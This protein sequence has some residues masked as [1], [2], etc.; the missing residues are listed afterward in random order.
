MELPQPDAPEVPHALHKS[1][2]ESQLRRFGRMLLQ[3]NNFG[4]ISVKSTKLNLLPAPGSVQ[5]PVFQAKDV[6]RYPGTAV[7]HAHFR[8]FPVHIMHDVSSEVGPHELVE[9]L[10]SENPEGHL[11]VT[12]MNPIEVL[13]RASSFEP[14]SH[15]IEYDLDSF[16]F[17]F[18]GSESESYFT[19][20]GVT[21]SWLRTSSV[22]ASNGRIY[23]VTLLDYKLGHCVWHIYCG[24]AEDQQT[25]TFSTGSYVRIPAVVSGT[26]SDEYLPV[27]L[28]SG[29]LD[30]VSR[31]PDLS[32]RNLSAKVSQ[33]ATGINPRATARDRW[34]ATYVASLLAPKKDFWWYLRKTFW[35]LMYAITFQWYMLSP[36]PDI[37]A[38]VEERKRTRVIHPTPGGGWSPRTKLNY[39]KASIPNMPSAL[40]RVSAFTASVFVFMIPKILVGEIITNVIIKLDYFGFFKTLW[41]LAEID[42]GRFLLTL[43]VIVVTAI[44]PGS[45]VKVFSRLAGH[46]WR[47]LWM[48]GWV[49]ASFEILVHEIVGAPGYTFLQTLPG[50]GWFYQAYLWIVASYSVLPGLPF[51]WAFPW[52]CLTVPHGWLFFAIWGCIVLEN[53]L[54]CMPEI[55]SPSSLPTYFWSPLRTVWHLWYH[56]RQS[57]VFHHLLF[58]H[59]RWVTWSVKVCLIWTYNRFRKLYIHPSMKGNCE[60]AGCLPAPNLAQPQTVRKRNVDVPLPSV[61]VIPHRIPT[62]HAVGDIA[63]DPIGL[64]LPDWREQ[65]L[66]A[67]RNDPNRFPQ[68]T[69]GQSCFWDCVAKFGGTPHMWYSWFMAF[70][71]RTP[72]PNDPVVGNVTLPEIQEFAVVSRFGVAISGLVSEV[73][74]PQGA[75]RPTLNLTLTRSALRNQLHIQWADPTT[76]PAPISNLAR[77]L[78]TIL[79][80]HPAW[81][82]AFQNTFNN[83]PVDRT[84]VPTGLLKTFAG[85]HELPVTREDIADAIIASRS[86]LPI[87]PPPNNEGFAFDRTTRYVAPYPPL[88]I[89]GNSISDVPIARTE[90]G[91]MWTRFR[92]LARTAA[93]RLRLKMTVKHPVE[94][95]D[96]KIGATRSQNSSNRNQGNV[97]PEPPMWVTLR[98]NLAE[99]LKAYRQIILP[100]VPLTEEVIQYTAD[101]PRAMRLVADLKAHPSVLES[102]ASPMVLQSLDSI[103]DAVKIQ[104]ETVTKPV[105]AFLGTWGSGKTTATIQFLHKLTPEQRRNVR[106]VSHTESLRAQSKLKLDFPELRGYN[107]PTIASIIAEP[108][109]GGV[110]FDDAGKYWGGTLDLVML[111][112]PLADFFVVNGDPL[113]TSSRFPVP[114]SQSEFDLS[115]IASI[116]GVAMKYAT[117]THRGFGLLANTLGV[118]TTNPN[119]G[120]ITHTLVGKSGIPVCTASPR[121]VQVLGSYGRQAYTYSSIQG[122]DFNQDLEVDMTGLEG[123]VLDSAAYVALTRS[124]TGVYMHMEAMDPNSNIRKP[125]TGS[126]IINALVYAVRSSNSSQLAGPDW[127]VKAAFYRHMA[128]SMP[129]LPWFASIGASVAVENFQQILPAARFHVVEEGLASSHSP[130]DATPPSDG[131]VDNIIPETHFIAKELREEVSRGGATDQFKE[132]A[133]VNPHVHKRNDTPTYFLSVEQRLK[134]SSYERNRKLMLSNP[135]K[136]M[137]DAY[138]KLVPEPPLWS[139][140]KH[141]HYVDTCIHEYCSKRT[142]SAVLD[143]LKRHDPDRTGS[144]I[145]ISLKNQVIKKDEKRH[146]LKAIPGQLIHE[147]DISVTLGDAPYA[148]FLENEII[149]AF[150]KNYLFYRRMSPPE[151]IS[152]YK[153]KWR[154]NNGAYSSDVTRWD[155]GCDAPLLNFDVHVMRRSRF[156]EE[157]INAYIERRLSSK[158]QHGVMAT[159]QNS[160]DRYTWPLNTV[161]R[162][163]VTSIVCSVAPEDTVAVNG[164][165]AAIDRNCSASHFPDSPW[166]FKDNNGHR[167]EFSGFNLGGPE[168]T[169]S[170]E[171]LWYRTTILIS[172]DPSAEDKWVNYLDLLQYTDL[173]SEYAID[174]ARSAHQ[175][176][177]TPGLFAECLPKLLRPHFPT[178]VF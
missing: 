152:A 172:R 122:E 37:Y 22:T 10:C 73:I 4:V 62:Q 141:Q 65:V 40:Q 175:H 68:L 7:K 13:D 18:T 167:V 156:P 106:I 87:L 77:V 89:F 12:G 165:D 100:A 52:Y 98:N 163:V 82:I 91:V 29:I 34:I 70:T 159:M 148:L 59:L 157:Y 94:D 19:S 174:V 118:H 117:I 177:R 178:V 120:H 28:L 101:L 2:E 46:F 108:S 112:N 171:G 103:L 20:C 136:D 54:A 75:D 127:L 169:Y 166:V 132:T 115:P 155:V 107:F 96:M 71:K 88:Y 31:T 32:T 93:G 109:T 41:R 3:P 84:P 11:V 110:I 158:S 9:K 23:H 124:K 147:Y 104:N 128:W 160:G 144:N 130:V 80:F 97:R 150:P 15:T 170:A 30:F 114:G 86:A 162:A 27:N 125:P 76:S 56:P 126:D 55:A 138:D 83:A 24:N 123:A 39:R 119:V 26:V 42:V 146:K 149:P 90:P 161:R 81:D 140:E 142:E 129:N 74:Q 131:P 113:Q 47:Q 79:R 25:R 1:I 99:E 168:P 72:N 60:R 69:P 133:F 176:M 58:E 153:A 16:N 6:T 173:N 135:R 164:D 35:N 50:R 95:P 45:I 53:L 66:T 143:K 102:R 145:V 67:Y 111:T 121:Y 134:S 78:A 21:N 63:V 85:E 154:F 38:Y 49:K 64:N 105:H 14:A 116:A 57:F 17:V 139:A 51:M 43:S 5:N 48:P 137:C 33:L 61:T 8:D 151:F 36:L 44:I 92:S